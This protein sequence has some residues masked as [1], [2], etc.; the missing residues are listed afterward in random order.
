MRRRPRSPD[1][2]LFSPHLIGWSVLQGGFAF[3]L[4]AAIFVI[5]YQHGMPET[6][7]RALAFFSL[8]MT[9]VGL[10]L[11]NRSFSASLITALRRPNPALV[12]VLVSVTTMLGLTLLWPSARGLFR[13]GPL[14]WDDLALT[15]GAGALVLVVLEVLKPIWRTRLEPS[16]E[17]KSGQS[18]RKPSDGHQL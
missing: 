7:V 6:E 9:I 15:L 3:A 2:P 8:V 17:I 13:F 10:I 16:P 4:V 1:E 11:V 18:D 12:W 14:H 5:G